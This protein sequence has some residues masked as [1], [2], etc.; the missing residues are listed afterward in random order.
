MIIVLSTYDI[1]SR[2]IFQQ[3][4]MFKTEYSSHEPEVS[5]S[6]KTENA[7]LDCDKKEIVNQPTDFICPR[8]RSPFLDIEKFLNHV[9]EHDRDDLH[10][11]STVTES[12]LNPSTKLLPENEHCQNDVELRTHSQ[13][14]ES[15]YGAE[16][17]KQIHS[18]KGHMNVEYVSFGEVFDGRTELPLNVPPLTGPSPSETTTG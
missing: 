10:L 13:L 7:E 18:K 11:N 8:C 6:V 4:T 2:S 1:Y 15:K 14:V 17:C 12:D 5:T 9:K 16:M 3:E